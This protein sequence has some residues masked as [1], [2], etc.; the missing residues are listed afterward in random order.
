MKL[1]PDSKVYVICPANRHTG[2]VETLHQLCSQL[3]SFGVDAYM[4]YFKGGSFNI[5]SD[6]VDPFYKKY[7]LPY[8][9]EIEDTEH[10]IFVAYEGPTHFLYIPKKAQRVLFWLSADNFLSWQAK[11]FKVIIA[12]TRLDSVPL[13]KVFN[14]F[15]P[16]DELV[17]FAQSEYVR[18]FLTINGVKN[19]KYVET[20]MNQTFLKQASNIDFTAKRNIVAYNPRKGFEVT[21]QLI[22]SAPD[23]AWRPIENMTTEQVQKFLATVKVY[24]DFGAFPGRERL[25]REAALSGC[26]VITGKRGVAGNDVDVNIPAEFKFDD[27]NLNPQQV[28]KKIREVFDNFEREFDKQKAFRDKELNARKNFVAQVAQAFGIEK[29]PSPYVALV[30]GVTDK[31]FQLAEQ[32]FQNKDFVP[33]FIIDDAM[34]STTTSDELIL[35]GQ[36]RNYVSIGKN[37]I[38]II[39]RDDAKFLYQEG[40][41]KIFAALEPTIKEL[42]TWKNSFAN[43]LIFNR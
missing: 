35:R 40:R 42:D 16:D 19:L 36:N 33:K 25:P 22:D 26:V 31:S 37:P 20:H 13:K 1:Y 10:N 27:G 23:I 18:Q 7:H 6:P 39:T 8:V 15:L 3:I 24:I 2:G 9:T 11:Y 21:K 5:K 4:H 32:L 14:F 34:A 28:I 12:N 17:H 29:F 41:I 38:E 43:L 30:Q